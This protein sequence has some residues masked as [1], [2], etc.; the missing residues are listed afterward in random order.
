MYLQNKYKK[1]AGRITLE[2]K[3][4]LSVYHQK[5]KGAAET[6]TPFIEQERLQSRFYVA[7]LFAVLLLFFIVPIFKSIV[8]MQFYGCS[9]RYLR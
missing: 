3:E 4:G 2:N 5:I 7:G 1:T 9:F 6:I 8:F